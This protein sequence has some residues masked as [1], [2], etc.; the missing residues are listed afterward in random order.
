MSRLLRRALP[1]FALAA[2]CGPALAS[3]PAEPP[4][5]PAR[6]DISVAPEQVSP[7]GRAEVTLRLTPKSGIRINRYPKIKL[8]V[9]AAP[10]LAG[11]AEVSLGNDGPPPAGAM[12]SNYFDEIDP[13]RLSLDIDEKAGPGRHEIGG[14]LVYYYCVKA[15]GFCAP[16]RLDVKIPVRVR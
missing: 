4:A 8:V 13:L 7:G 9:P 15:S 12:E 6:I 3:V 11:Q 1:L 14:K 10:G 5:E 2:A 16:A